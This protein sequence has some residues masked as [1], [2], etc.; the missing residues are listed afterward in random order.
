MKT[1][2]HAAIPSFSTIRP[3][4]LHLSLSRPLLLAISAL[5]SAL[6]FLSTA[7]SVA[8]MHSE[9]RHYL[10]MEDYVGVVPQH[11]EAAILE[12]TPL[13]TSYADVSRYLASRS[14]GAD[15]NI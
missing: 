13:G 7:G 14:I 4:E 2:S 12:H 1:Y 5:L 8:T 15:F 9:V 3:I 10:G 6:L 11:V